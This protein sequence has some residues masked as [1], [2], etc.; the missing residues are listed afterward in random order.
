MLT[1]EIELAAGARLINWMGDKVSSH[2]CPARSQT[3]PK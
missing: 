1:H 2:D 3:R